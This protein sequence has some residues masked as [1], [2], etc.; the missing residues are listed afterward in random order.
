MNGS[1]NGLDAILKI[2][3]KD[4]IAKDLEYAHSIDTS[5][6]VISEKR[7]KK[8]R[9]AIKNYEKQSLWLELPLACRRVVAAVLI[10]CTMS[11]SLCL[12]VEA[13]RAEIANTIIEWYEKFVSVFYVT[14]IEAPDT[15]EEY[16]EPT[17]Q[18]AGTERQ[19]I[20]QGDMSYH[21]IYSSD[22]SVMLSY[23]QD[24]IRDESI[25]L[26]IEN[27]CTQEKFEI[28]GCDAIL[29]IY[30]NGNKGITWNDGEYYYVIYSYTDNIDNREL[31]L[32]AESVE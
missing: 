25:D 13:I 32:I 17:L 9:R 27:N 1:N 20:L 31:K 10:I 16:R 2:A 29:F 24:V 5:Q 7:L 4:L 23:Q 28:N 11:F 8:S 21:I 14:Q 12:S 22:D 15:I 30:D 6:T 19:V 18:I 26:D 3:A